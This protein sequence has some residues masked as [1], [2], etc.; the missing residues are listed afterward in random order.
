MLVSVLLRYLRKV[1]TPLV[2][3][4]TTGS[5]VAILANLFIRIKGEE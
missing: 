3:G 5:V 2:S 1:I 4:I